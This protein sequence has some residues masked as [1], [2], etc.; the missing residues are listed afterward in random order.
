MQLPTQAE[1]NA[2]TRHLASFAGG[3]ILAFGLSGKIDPQTVQNI[4]GAA[5]TLVNDGVILVGLVAPLVAGYFAKQ[6]ATPAAQASAVVQ[7]AQA[8]TLPP[9]AQAQVAAALSTAPATAMGKGSL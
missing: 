5:G 2:A 1:V 6:S 8:G 4:I 3:V 7:A 9:P